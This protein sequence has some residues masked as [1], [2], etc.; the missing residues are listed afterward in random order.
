MQKFFPSILSKN[1][2]PGSLRKHI[3]AA[4]RK[5]TRHNNNSRGKCSQRFLVAL[6]DENNLEAKTRH[7]GLRKKIATNKSQ[8][9]SQH[10]R[11]SWYGAVC[12]CSCFCV[13]QQELHF[14]V[15]YKA[16]SSKLAGW[17]K[18]HVPNWFAE[19]EFEKKVFFANAN[20]LVDKILCCPRIKPSKSQIFMMLD[21]VE[22][23]MLSSDFAQQLRSKN[24]DVPDIFFTLLDATV[25]SLTL[26]LN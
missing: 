20:F 14:L 4:Q 16:K 26:L 19:E 24:A 6:S 3:K 13:Q 11:L 9:S 23:G 12:Y 21:G 22:T 17:A 5:P 10:F 7:P 2:Y 1:V 8:H 15:L 18:S 25:I